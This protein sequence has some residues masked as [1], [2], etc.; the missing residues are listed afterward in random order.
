[1][2]PRIVAATALLGVVTAA[3]AVP[4]AMQQPTAPFTASTD[5]VI[6]PVV[7]EDKK[8]A[9]VTN[10]TAADFTLMEDGRPVVI[11]TFV[12]PEAESEAR[13]G[14]RF[15]VLA[16]DNINTPAEIA[17]RVKDIA[18]LFVDRMRPGDD[19]SVITLASGAASSGHG[20]EAARAT[21]RRFAPTMATIRT[22]AEVVREGLEAIASLS[23]QMGKSPHPRKVLAI[24]GAA[25]MFNPGEPS[26]FADVGAN[27]AV[28]WEHAVGA[29]SRHN[30]S[31]YLIDPRGQ[32]AVA[33]D[34]SSFSGPSGGATGSGYGPNARQSFVYSGV[35]TSLG[36][37]NHTG[38]QSWVNT[39]NYK[40]A[41]N[42]IWRESATYYLLGYRVPINDHRLHD[43][44]IKVSRPGLTVSARKERG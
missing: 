11:E 14:G 44:D 28:Q 32:R 15:V 26:A 22:R 43:V 6:V 10:L 30:I 39:N 4:V 37:T 27:Q 17:W 19:L 34:A 1:M 23:E 35:D 9:P 8:G 16:L 38:G 24:I 41:V 20:P 33:D 36:F 29:A 18:M 31:V 7:V 13:D 42:T 5:L 12:A 40:G 2:R 25:Y 3:G 21:I